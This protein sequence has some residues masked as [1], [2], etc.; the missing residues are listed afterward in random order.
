MIFFSIIVP[1]FNSSKYIEECFESLKAQSIK[2]SLFEVIFIDD[3]SIDDTPCKIDRLCK[4][5]KNI[6]LIKLSKNGGPGHARNYGIKAAS[7]E[8][9]I[10]LDSDDTL[11]NSALEKLYKLMNIEQNKTLDLFGYNWE[12][13]NLANSN[14][15]IK[16]S[17]YSGRRDLPYLESKQIT[18]NSYLE[19]KMDGSVIYTAIRKSILIKN[20]IFFADGFHEDVDFIFKVY[21][22]SENT[23]Y[24][25]DVIY[26]KRAH[27]LSIVNNIS[28][29]HIDGYFRAWFEIYY[30]LQKNTSQELF[31]NYLSCMRTGSIAVIAT[32]IR[33]VARHLINLDSGKKYLDLIHEKIRSL[34]SAK[35]LD[36]NVKEKTLY[37]KIYLQF[38]E[39]MKAKK[40]EKIKAK[41]FLKNIRALD[42][43]TW[44][45]T[46]LHNS[47]FLKE[48]QVRTCCKRYFLD[49]E[50][51]GDVVLL[52]STEEIDFN[53]Q[54]ILKAKRN[55]HHKINAGEKCACDGCPFMEFKNWGPM[56]SLNIKYLSLEHHSICN[57]RCTY[58][59]DEYYGGRKPV[60]DTQKLLQDLI[61]QSAME[62]CEI[63]VWGGGE[64][65]IGKE[66]AVMSK[67]IGEQI[68]RA[69]QR[70]LTNSV[71]FSSELE[72]LLKRNRAQIVTSIDAGTKETF[73]KIRGAKKINQVL[74]NLQKYAQ[75]SCSLVTIKYIFTEG[76]STTK[77]ICSF[78][79][80]IK[81]FELLSCNFQI[82]GD[83]KNESVSSKDSSNMVIL[84]GMLRKA[85]ARFIYIDELVRHRWIK[86]PNLKENIKINIPDEVRDYNFI[87]DPKLYKNIVIW[88][89]G[90]QAKYL[91]NKTNFFKEVNPKY[92]VDSKL[93]GIKKKFEG[94]NI[95]NPEVLLKNNHPI[96]IAA[97]QGYPLVVNE[98]I[99]Y[100]ISESRIIK[101]LVL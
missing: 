20:S 2:S 43:K 24:T 81:K 10:F 90:Q 93:F 8:W 53:P 77:E 63:V 54:N 34:L 13:M 1:T 33:E 80:L 16:C 41:E 79:D 89:A 72:D 3:F 47:V 39:F 6:R 99:E 73:H 40:I 42:G 14:R 95:K 57:L 28:I 29:D 45:C 101:D 23:D 46:D 30:F 37:S 64:P 58:C 15:R 87:A 60:Y 52:D 59:S 96:L 12:Y 36:I 44:S 62:N 48:N 32:R 98:L 66:F 18:I 88:G 4:N 9:I 31:E 26:K 75:I 92:F 71:K 56:N 100:G 65:T 78:V 94:F 55:L 19:H 67:I 70:V 82:S 17:P 25:T 61:D 97:V 7:G 35:I 49:G 84:Y 83:F 68:P 69:K 86:P 91:L 51:K 27:N 85:G 50:I 74:N 21:F 5:N 38:N 11:T 76:N 22:Y